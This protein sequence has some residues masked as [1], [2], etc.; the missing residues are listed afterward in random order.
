MDFELGMYLVIGVPILIVMCIYLLVTSIKYFK[1]KIFLKINGVRTTATVTNVKVH[2]FKHRRV[3][4]TMYTHTL[5]FEV[6][7]VK[8]ET[9]AE[10]KKAFKIGSLYYVVYNRKNP[11]DAMPEDGINKGPLMIIINLLALLGG[12][13][14]IFVFIMVAYYLIY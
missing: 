12:I 10:E 3:H 13:I 11:N 2:T 1:Q 6:D 5:E 9:S 7:G 14:I 4:Y 8:Y